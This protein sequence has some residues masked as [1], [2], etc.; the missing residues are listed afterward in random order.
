MHDKYT[1]RREAILADITSNTS[2][3]FGIEIL[4]VHVSLY[5]SVSVTA[6]IVT[7]RMNL[8]PIF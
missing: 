3:V 4:S 6:C 8:L 7:K 5:L 2:A 1:D